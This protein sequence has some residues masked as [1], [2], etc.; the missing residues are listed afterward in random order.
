MHRIVTCFMVALGL[1]AASQ[2]FAQSEQAHPGDLPTD[3]NVMARAN[4][5]EG[6]L[7]SQL[8][9]ANPIVE[10]VIQRLV[11]AGKG[12]LQAQSRLLLLGEAQRQ[13]PRN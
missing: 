7:Q 2:L 11:P 12:R 9:D 6:F 3:R 4:R 5:A 10:A 1:V 13:G 8:E